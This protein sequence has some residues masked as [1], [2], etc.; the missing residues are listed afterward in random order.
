M[1]KDTVAVMQRFRHNGDVDYQVGNIQ[2]E[3]DVEIEGTVKVRFRVEATGD[4]LID[5]AVER[6]ARV[7][8]GG[9]LVVRRGI[10]GAQV[11]AGG[12]L[13]ALFI[14]DSEVTVGGDLLVRNY[15]QNS[16][17]EVQGKATI[18]GDQGGQRQLCL[19]GGTL[20]AAQEIDAASIGSMYGRV[21]RAVAGV[22]SEV[23]AR[24]EKYSKGLS[25]CD[26]RIQRAM[27]TLESQIGP[28]G[29]KGAV[30]GAIQNAPPG[31]REFLRTQLKE[32]SDT[33]KLRVNLE[34]HLGE[35]RRQRVAAAA[36]AQI[37]ISGTA[38]QR[39]NLQIGRVY[40]T[41]DENIQEVVLWTS[42]TEI[43]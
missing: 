18:Q 31:R 2:M 15:C 28:L 4:V 8:A 36:R 23:E 20:L 43:C 1:V 11:K 7:V 39:T 41:L 37:R 38:F 40:Q 16:E 42:K 9:N 3:G 25:F 32:I 24:L 14:Q 34:H 5:G 30:V 21:T 13:Y 27:R 19:L 22:D 17:V 10:I 35:L 6:G 12:N 26:I 29:R 33:Q